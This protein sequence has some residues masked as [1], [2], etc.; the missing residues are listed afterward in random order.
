MEKTTY[1][2]TFEEVS[3]SD[4]NR[5]AEELRNA[6]LDAAPDI[7]VQRK[8]ES[9]QAQD[10]G[11]SLVLI[12]GTP[13]ATTAVSAVVTAVDNWLRLRRNASLNWKSADGEITIRNISSKN[14]VELAQVLLNKK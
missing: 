12:L 11:T 8:R 4:A 13:V 7:I 14:V 5:Y 6:L 9:P 10:F 2:V 3:P 1:H